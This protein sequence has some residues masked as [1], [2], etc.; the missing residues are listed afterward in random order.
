LETQEQIARENQY[1]GKVYWICLCKRLSVPA[2][3]KALACKCRKLASSFRER[4]A[5]RNKRG[6]DLPDEWQTGQFR[7]PGGMVRLRQNG[8]DDD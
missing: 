8:E 5:T 2:K 6:N 1:I 3:V 4:F 7:K